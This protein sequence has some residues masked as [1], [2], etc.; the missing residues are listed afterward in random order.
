M[1]EQAR[2][3]TAVE[4]T[5][6]NCELFRAQIAE[7]AR[8]IERLQLTCND[9]DD[10]NDRIYAELADLKANRDA[11]MLVHRVGRALDQQRIE[12]AAD[13]CE[14]L[15]ARLAKYEDA[16]GNPITTIAEQAR[17]IE[18]LK[19]A[20]LVSQRS[21][22]SIA[23]ELRAELSDLKAQ[24]RGVVRWPEADEIMQM[25]FEEGQPGEDASGYYFELEEFDLFIQR[26][27][28][29]V[30]RLNSSL[31]SSAP[32][33]SEQVRQMVPEG[34]TVERDVFGTIHIK[35]GDFD[36]IQIRY[37]YPYTDNA[38]TW[39]LAERIAALLSAPSAGS[40]GGD[41]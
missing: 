31:V 14:V 37:Q 7:Q 34:V 22:V 2:I 40:Q 17:E 18:T 30:A 35:S 3:E 4:M 24:P 5:I 33:H 11:L 38:G 29:E 10:Q 39:R 12:T 13:D 1:S 32:N 16:E 27:M 25:A 26:L 23:T 9:L 21:A 41:A 20:V 15:R 6:D 36:F 19:S 28:E 8:E